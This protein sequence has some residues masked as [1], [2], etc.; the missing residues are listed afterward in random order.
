MKKEYIDYALK[1]QPI[2]DLII[3]ISNLIDSND[4]ETLEKSVS[5]YEY[6]SKEL[7]SIVPP[8]V[9]KELSD[10]LNNALVVW[11]GTVKKMVVLGTDEEA[12][13]QIA[14]QKNAETVIKNIIDEIV[15]TFQN[16]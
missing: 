15:F 12:K 2:G 7:Q 6:A 1:L 4:A 8:K 3:E 14:A 16:N 13:K 11:I 10:Q 5:R 9:I